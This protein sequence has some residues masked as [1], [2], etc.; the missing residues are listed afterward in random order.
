MS[1]SPLSPCST[2]GYSVSC[3][4]KFVATYGFVTI[5]LMAVVA[6]GVIGMLMV[7]LRKK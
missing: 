2:V 1:A 5:P 6:F 3:A 7:L 4:E